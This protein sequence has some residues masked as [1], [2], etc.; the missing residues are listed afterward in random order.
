AGPNWSL[1]QEFMKS[2]GTR[3][4]VPKLVV[5]EALNHY[6]EGLLQK[7]DEAKRALGKLSKFHS[8]PSGF[9]LPEISL[10]KAMN[11]YEQALSL[12]LGVLGA[13][14]P[15]YAEIHVKKIVERALSRRKPF[16]QNGQ[17]GFRDAL[18]W[19]TVLNILE[20]TQDEVR[21]VTGNVND[22]GSHGSLA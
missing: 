12:R 15:D 20:K 4:I 17:A 10:E 14:L 11:D 9:C 3:L 1:L 18:I 6:R 22:F 13:E 19:E 8:L 5:Q 21:F 2:E 7:I 16:D